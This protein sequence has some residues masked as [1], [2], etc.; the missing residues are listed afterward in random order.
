MPNFK[1]MPMTP[2]Q[3]LLFPMSV[4]ESVPRD[5]DV[6]V[7]GEA[8]DLLD[9]SVFEA[10]Y[11]ETGCP[12]YP[13][14]VLAKVL[15]YG[16]SKGIRSSRAL[17]DAVKNDKR[18][19]WLAGGLEPDHTTIARFRKEKASELRDVYRGSVRI[20]AEAGLI[21]L[22]VT[23]T[24]GSKIKARA[25][26]KSLYDAKR[27]AKEMEAIDRIFAEAEEVDRREDELHGSG[28]GNEMPAELA[29]AAKR[30]EKLQEI[31]ERLRKTG[32]NSASSTDEECRVMKTTDGLRPSY[33]VQ[34]TVDTANQVI[35]A[36]DVTNNETD[37]GQ[38][39]AQLE[40]VVENTGC[41]PDV[42]LADTGYSDERTY[43]TLASLGQ[44]A[45]MPPRRQPREKKRKDLFASKC[46]LRD[47][48]RDV[49]ICPA[50]RELPYYREV[51]CSSG[52]YKEYRAFGCRS[53]SFYDECVT[54]TCKTGRAVQ[55]S[56]VAAERQAMIERLETPEGR[57]LYS[58]R[59]QTVE[60]VFGNIKANM[61][62]SRFGLHGR[63]GAQSE[64]WLI[65]IAHNLKIY[66][67]RRGAPVACALSCALVWLMGVAGGLVETKPRH[68]VLLAARAWA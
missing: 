13:P 1:Q 48:E 37:K 12:P 17:E 28:T 26:K 62:L 20:C 55:V 47:G 5:S 15:V 16:Y 10:G 54:V 29:D 42:M 46:F 43:E 4:E 44:D 50:G 21:L 7:L 51:R 36:A 22:D 11:S 25:S 31:A 59:Q 2:S 3:V 38:L 67:R 32:R 19:I 8:M 24:D 35:V 66:A 60:P 34:I 61:G 30:K 68:D 53:C 39:P 14:K 23:A 27:V 65:C 18:Y 57:R 56:I 52:R 33:N 9:W 58:L 49:L 40:E 64:T 45:L 6:R 41:S 63:E